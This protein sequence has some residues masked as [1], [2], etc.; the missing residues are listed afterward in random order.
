[1]LKNIV[2]ILAGLM[3]CSTPVFAQTGGIKGNLHLEYG[4]KELNN[5]DWG[6][7]TDGM[8]L[9]S[10]KEIAVVGDFSIS[11]WPFHIAF[12]FSRSSD[13]NVESQSSTFFFDPQFGA[14]NAVYTGKFS[15][16]TTELQLGIRKYFPMVS[17]INLYM[18]GGFVQI[19]AE[20]KRDRRTNITGGGFP[21]LST[22]DSNSY[23]DSDVGLWVDSGIVVSPIQNFIVGAKIS[24][25]QATVK[26]AGEKVEAGGFHFGIFTGLSW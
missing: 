23:S 24:F 21:P 8:D 19:N 12:G 4:I 9:G 14:M 22:E 6:D 17:L 20:L 1:M 18:G 3:S 25:S 26:F 2:G 13:R 11:G 16:S 7:A 5:G 15:G 10:Q